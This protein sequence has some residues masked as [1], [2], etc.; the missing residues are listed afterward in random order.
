MSTSTD[1]QHNT[2]HYVHDFAFTEY[3]KDSNCQ[4]PLLMLVIG[5]KHAGEFDWDNVIIENTR[6]VDADSHKEYRF[7]M[8]LS[9]DLRVGGA[10]YRILL[11]LEHKSYSDPNLQKQLLGYQWV[12]YQSS[13]DPVVPIVI[14]HGKERLDKLPSFQDSLTYGDH[15]VRKAV[16][17]VFGRALLDFEA[18]F[19]NLCS[20]ARGEML[21]HPSLDCMVH[22]MGNIHEF[23]WDEMRTLREKA[24]RIVEFKERKRMI[25]LSL[26]YIE[27]VHPGRFDM[28]EVAALE[29]E[30]EPDP[31]QR[32]LSEIETIK[33]LEAW[34]AYDKYDQGR[35][36]NAREIAIRLIAT[37]DDLDKICSVTEL[38]R[39]EVEKLRDQHSG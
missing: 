21:V 13:D 7:D 2:N 18:I 12:H 38:S 33:D 23:T 4:V 20:L 25:M 11:L 8:A 32:V 35:E 17:R 34:F 15:R 19:V 24:V 16:Q 26:K 9:V 22:T 36:E 14:Y 37:G 39:D 3:L 28:K 27:K 5:D 30:I 1:R 6:K 31:E 10:R 29:R